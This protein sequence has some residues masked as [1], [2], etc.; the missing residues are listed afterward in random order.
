ML[1]SFSRHNSAVRV[2]ARH[3]QVQLSVLHITYVVTIV[4]VFT[5]VR[6]QVHIEPPGQRP[7]SHLGR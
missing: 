3:S 4:L 6:I 1:F 5:N 2:F 7:S